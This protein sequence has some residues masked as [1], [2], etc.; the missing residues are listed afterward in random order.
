M[1]RRGVLAGQACLLSA[2]MDGVPYPQPLAGPE[3]QYVPWGVLLVRPISTPPGR[4]HR[5]PLTYGPG[6]I[7]PYCLCS[8]RADTVTG[9]ASKPVRL[10]PSPAFPVGPF[11]PIPS[12]LVGF[13]EVVFPS[14]LGGVGCWWWGGGSSP[15]RAGLLVCVTPPLLAEGPWCSS[16]PLLAAVCWLLWWPFPR[17]QVGGFPCC[18][19]LW[20]GACWCVRGVFVVVVLVWVCL[21]CVLV[22]VWRVA[23]GFPGSGLLVVQVWVW[24]VCVV[25]GSSPLLAEVPE[26][27]SPPLLAGF[28]WR[29]WWVF[30]AT[31]G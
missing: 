15:L 4:C 22:R 29:W 14:P 12:F 8:G 24:L 6:R 31:P 21:P 11:R 19:C 17:G 25:G 13:V 20:R 18:V 26:C 28:C 30:L 9:G 1:G 2:P 5:G 10:G 27:V 16:P 23:V 7:P 3:P